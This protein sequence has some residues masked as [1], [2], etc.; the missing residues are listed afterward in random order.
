MQ[1]YE[2]L[3]TLSRKIHTLSSI[4]KILD[5]DQETYMPSDA[6]RFRSEQVALIASL[7]HTE[8]TSPEFRKALSALIDIESGKFQVQGLSDAQKS[9]LKRFRYDFIRDNKLPL[10]FVKK[11]AQVTSESTAIWGKAKKE[12]NFSLFCA[13]SRNHS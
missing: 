4:S 3:K 12:N 10:A 2:D 13:L 1:A 6:F 7:T 8:K 11:W 9:A 5:W